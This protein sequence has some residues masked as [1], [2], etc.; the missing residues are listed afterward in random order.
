MFSYGQLI[1]DV[2]KEIPRINVAFQPDLFGDAMQITIPK[3]RNMNVSVSR[4]NFWDT[5]YGTVA[6]NELL[7]SVI[8]RLKVMIESKKNKVVKQ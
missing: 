3:I 4:A 7:T 1:D 8:N 2:R 5:K 6:Y